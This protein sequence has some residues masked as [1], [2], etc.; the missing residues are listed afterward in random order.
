MVRAALNRLGVTR[1]M[2]DYLR[3]INDIVEEATE[4]E[5]LP[6]Y[7]ITRDTSIDEAIVPHLGG[8]RGFGPI[9]IGNQAHI[10]V[11]NDVYGSVV[12]VSTHAFFDQRL[13]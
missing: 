4:G 3:F 11:Q 2:E 13:A 8:Y 7:G 12:L 5:L 10:Q 6:V 9:R 1:T